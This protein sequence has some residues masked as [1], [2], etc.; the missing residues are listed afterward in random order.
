MVV[1]DSMHNHL[2]NQVHHH[3]RYRL[4]ISEDEQADVPPTAEQIQ[5]AIALFQKGN[6]EQSV[7]E[8]KSR[9]KTLKVLCNLHGL[10]MGERAKKKDMIV[11]LQ[12]RIQADIMSPVPD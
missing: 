10:G 2:L 5:E 11:E 9:V 4:G 1:V 7:L 3:F 12:V 8:K 6:I